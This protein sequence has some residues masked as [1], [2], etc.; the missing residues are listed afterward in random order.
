MR[1]GVHLLIELLFYEK[2]ELGSKRGCKLADRK[3]VALQSQHHFYVG[4]APILKDII[5]CATP[6]TLTPDATTVQYT[7]RKGLWWSKDDNPWIAL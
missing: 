5:Y 3:L 2:F 7:K 1:V 4:F 6:G